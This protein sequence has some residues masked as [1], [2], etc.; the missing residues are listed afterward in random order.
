MWK[1]AWQAAAA[2]SVQGDTS[3]PNKWRED[4]V[5]KKKKRAARVA[6]QRAQQRAY[7]GFWD[8]EQAFEEVASTNGSW[9]WALAGLAADGVGL[10]LTG[11]GRRGI[12]EMAGSLSMNPCLFGVLRVHLVSAE[13]RALFRFFFVQASNIDSE[14]KEEREIFTQRQRGAAMGAMPIIRDAVEKYVKCTGKLLIKSSTDC[15][16]DNLL[17]TAVLK[18]VTGAEREFSTL[19]SYERGEDAYR[20]ANPGFFNEE[21]EHRCVIAKQ[22]QK[23][24]AMKSLVAKNAKT[25]VLEDDV[26]M[27]DVNFEEFKPFSLAGPGSPDVG[28]FSDVGGSDV[29]G[30]PDVED[31]GP[32]PSGAAAICALTGSTSTVDMAVDVNSKFLPGSRQTVKTILEDTQAA[33]AAVPSD[34]PPPSAPVTDADVVLPTPE[35]DVLLAPDA[36]PRPSSQHGLP[37]ASQQ[38][39]LPGVVANMPHSALRQP[40]PSPE[41][42]EKSQ[43]RH[44]IQF[45]VDPDSPTS[46]VPYDPDPPIASDDQFPG[47]TTCYDVTSNNTAESVQPV[48]TMETPDNGVMMQTTETTRT[49][50]SSH[51]LASGVIKAMRSTKKAPDVNAAVTEARRTRENFQA[52]LRQSEAAT[53]GAGDTSGAKPEADEAAEGGKATAASPKADVDVGAEGGESPAAPPTADVDVGAEDGTSPAAPPKADVDFGA[54][55]VEGIAASPKADADVGAGGGESPVPLNADVDVVAKGGE[56]PLASPQ[57]NVD[58]EAIAGESPAAP[59][60]TDADV[61]AEGGLPQLPPILVQEPDS[62]GSENAVEPRSSA[63]S[64]STANLS[65][66][67]RL[68]LKKAEKHAAHQQ[69]VSKGKAALLE[70]KMMSQ[71]TPQ[72]SESQRWSQ[73]SQPSQPSQPLQEA[74]SSSSSSSSSDD[75][76]AAGL[77]QRRSGN[78]GVPGQPSSASS[79]TKNRGSDRKKKSQERSNQMNGSSS[80]ASGSTGRQREAVKAY[81]KGDFVDVW[82]VKFSRWYD[83][84]EVVDR[85]DETC[86]VDHVQVQA[87]SVQVVFGL[88]KMYRWVAPVMVKRHL[89]DSLRPQPPEAMSGVLKKETHGWFGFSEWHDRYVEIQRGYIHWW[90]NEQEAQINEPVKKVYLLGTRIKE[91]VNKFKLVTDGS[92]GVIYQFEA[93]SYDSMLAWSEACYEHAEFCEELNEFDQAKKTNKGKEH[94]QAMK[95]SWEQRRENRRAERL[96]NRT[97]FQ[98]VE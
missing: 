21:E 10:E 63:N 18:S 32:L 77:E 11:G 81:R 79:G 54:E 88:G 30:L 69:L 37:F 90:R 55:G 61:G 2:S 48:D 9:N 46:Y 31:K 60:K 97:E 96:L 13:G 33:K 83:D 73:R 20:E 45:K 14:E 91:K 67:E 78:S 27:C 71:L 43:D 5:A 93:E 92:Q 47:E 39:S 24:P 26:D 57:A 68:K 95:E 19:E 72:T 89:R 4:L 74:S 58:V 85:V 7:N 66:K 16:V 82:S 52:S 8:A 6:K 56:S 80:N 29:G 64:G 38:Q 44:H 76:T 17:V 3:T 1:T 23:L 36:D 84:G 70:K 35:S 98:W 86:Y 51:A 94:M 25:W 15:T 75:E 65:L 49:T 12:E 50:C 28:G 87:G 34:A 42:G 62:R 59:P 40:S 22:M 53:A 41:P